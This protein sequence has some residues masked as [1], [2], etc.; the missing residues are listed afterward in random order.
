M[1]LFEVHHIYEIN[2]KQKEHQVKK[3]RGCGYKVKLTIQP[4]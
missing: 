4:V 3:G 2:S 1:K